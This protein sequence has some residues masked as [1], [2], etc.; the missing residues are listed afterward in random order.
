MAL[1]LIK[2]ISHLKQMSRTTHLSENVEF[3]ISTHFVFWNFVISV[4]N[5]ILI[6]ISDE[7]PV[8]A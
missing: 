6:Y 1:K 5:T 7:Q 3:V 4:H 8:L 2:N